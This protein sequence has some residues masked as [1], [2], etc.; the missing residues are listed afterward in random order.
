[1]KL[2]HV[3]RKGLIA[4]SGSLALQSSGLSTHGDYYW[5]EKPVKDF[6]S[7][8]NSVTEHFFEAVRYQSFSHMPSRFHSFFA[9]QPEDLKPWVDLFTRTGP[10]VNRVWEIEVKEEACMRL[11]AAL[12]KT[13]WLYDDGHW[14][15]PAF[16][17]VCAHAY[18]GQSSIDTLR[19]GRSP[20]PSPWGSAPMWEC[21]VAFP[22]EVVRM[23]SQSELD[24]L[25]RR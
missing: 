14:F 3:D 9:C 1:M 20:Q 4:S 17:K 18:W 5:L 16:A 6:G 24:Q 10:P 25:L 2:Y 19:D 21:L 8:L 12:L 22:F 7:V 11:D 23:L 15:D 13:F